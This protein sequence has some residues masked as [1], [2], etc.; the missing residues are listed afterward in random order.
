MEKYYY[1]EGILFLLLFMI[2]KVAS[3]SRF[4]LVFQVFN[5]V[6]HSILSGDIA[7]PLSVEKKT[8]VLQQD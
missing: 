2:V 1:A 8:C 3:G 7:F 5:I 6:P 4:A